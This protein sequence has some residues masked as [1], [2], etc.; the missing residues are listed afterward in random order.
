MTNRLRG[1][2]VPIVSFRHVITCIRLER[3][4]WVTKVHAR[5]VSLDGPN[6]AVILV[7]PAKSPTR[8]DRGLVTKNMNFKLN[9]SS[10]PTRKEETNTLALSKR[11]PFVPTA[12]NSS[13]VD[14]NFVN[15]K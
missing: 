7:F 6:N 5:S 4:L 13:P 14:E 10:G 8:S 15:V 12:V 9:R 1:T 3:H 2:V 11:G